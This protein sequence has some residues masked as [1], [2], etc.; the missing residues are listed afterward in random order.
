MRLS[1]R[2]L[3]PP[4]FQR[5]YEGEAHARAPR[6]ARISPPRPRSVVVLGARGADN[7][8]RVRQHGGNGNAVQQHRD[9]TVR[10]SHASVCVILNCF[11]G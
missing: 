3:A 5:R 11:S 2:S 9:R 8:D 7:S 6:V 1:Y 10:D 4:R